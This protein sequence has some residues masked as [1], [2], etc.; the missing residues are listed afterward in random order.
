M[1][2]AAH[3]RRNMNGVVRRDSR[4]VSCIGHDPVA[5]L[6][7]AVGAKRPSVVS[8]GCLTVPGLVQTARATGAV[9]SPLGCS[10][11]K[12]KNGT[13]HIRTASA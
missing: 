9:T 10:W 12:F 3:H 2:T 1:L 5:F 7:L 4:Q 6:R 8:T 11:L 13:A